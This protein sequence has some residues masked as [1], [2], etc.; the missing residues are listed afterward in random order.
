MRSRVCE[1]VERPLVRPPHVAAAGLLLRARRQGDIHRLLH[2]RRSATN[3]SS[4]TSS[5]GVGSWTQTSYCRRGGCRCSF[6]LR[7]CPVITRWRR[8]RH[9][10]S[11]RPPARRRRCRR[12][13]SLR[14]RWPPPARWSPARQVRWSPARRR[15]LRRR[16]W[17]R[18]RCCR[19][20]AP[21]AHCSS[22]ISASRAPSKT[23]AT[24]SARAY[25]VP[26]H[27]RNFICDDSDLSPPLF[28]QWNLQYFKQL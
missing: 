20:P 1:T 7:C 3:T 16:R 23:S 18:T 12:W 13:P 8:R 17:A 4:V 10:R 2:G 24:S 25:R 26:P 11:R 28:S 6:T 9:L 14:R 21:T 27:R 22:P 15:W 19:R 5:A